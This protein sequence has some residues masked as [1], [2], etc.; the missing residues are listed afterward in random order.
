MQSHA[1]QC[2]L[3]VSILSGAA[4]AGDEAPPAAKSSNL[5]PGVK[6]IRDVQY[7]KINDIVLKMD[8]YLP[9]DA[10]AAMP[11]VVY[12]HGGGWRRGSKSGC[13]AAIPL[14]AKGYIVASVDYRL[15]QQAIFPA[16][17]EDCKGAV[18]FLRANAAK[19]FIDPKSIITMG[20][21]AGGH[22]AS[23]M[24][25]SAGA[26]DLEGTTGGNLDQS[27]TV[28]AVIDYY[29]PID[30][31]AIIDQK[32]DVKRGEIGAPEVQLLGGR[33]LEHKDLAIKASPLTY[34]TKDVPPFLIVHGEKDPRVPM[35]QPKAMLE[36]VKNIG[37]EA[38]LH[39]V[40][41][42]SH[43]FTAAQNAELI[44]VLTEFLDK[45]FKTPAVKA[46]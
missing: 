17:I 42:G 31:I 14:A 39:I 16:A 36:A 5:P 46:P 12:F 4:V 30:F 13:S 18:R 21:S 34:V 33:T 7:A 1:C 38:T 41:N 35:E 27:S 22:L 32:S 40:K 37:G 20:D 2:L 23:L 6:V 43:G 8:I 45:H 10:K 11:A 44:P 26:K 24:G 3:L 29:G 9:E 19:Y 15:S 25:T 28:Q